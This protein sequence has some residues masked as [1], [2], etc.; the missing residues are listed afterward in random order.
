MLRTP[1]LKLSAIKTTH[2]LKAMHTKPT[3]SQ[4]TSQMMVIELIK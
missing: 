4:K 1:M 3:T 2:Q